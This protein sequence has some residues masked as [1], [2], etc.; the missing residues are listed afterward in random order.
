MKRGPPS[1]KIFPFTPMTKDPSTNGNHPLRKSENYYSQGSE[2]SGVRL[3]FRTL[4]Y[5]NYRLF[6]IGNGISMIGSWMQQIAMSWLVY[7]LTNSAL[8]LGVIAFAGLFPGFLLT[9]LAGVLSDRWNRSHIILVAQVLEMLQA[10]VL[11]FLVVTDM[12]AVWHIILLSV[13]VGLV[14]A[15]EV[16]ARQSFVVHII[17]RREDLGSAIA[18]NSAMFNGARLI[19]PTIAGVTIAV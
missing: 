15:F 18:L 7:R 3:I 10:L 19:G 12:I 5:R 13:F 16:P 17:D 1:R 6:F 11:A 2:V 9:P 14:I 4:S 8:L